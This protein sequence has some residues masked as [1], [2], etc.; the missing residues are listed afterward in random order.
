LARSPLDHLNEIKGFATM[1]YDGF[2]ILLAV[3]LGLVP[4][5]RGGR[6]NW[7]IVEWNTALNTCFWF[8][9]FFA[10]LVGFLRLFGLG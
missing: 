8:G 5:C 7:N 10:L 1:R 2:V 4:I 9:W 3:M 6:W